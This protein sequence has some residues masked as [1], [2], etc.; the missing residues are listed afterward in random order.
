VLS[1]A[2]Q[3]KVLLDVLGRAGLTGPDQ[4]LPLSVRLRQGVGRDGKRLRYYLNYSRAPQSFAYP[5]PAGTDL[6]T[7]M[8][9]EKGQAVALEPWGLVI[10]EEG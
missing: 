9:V 10:V 6:L 8:A 4:D 5:H 3:R 2:L 7:G 1:D